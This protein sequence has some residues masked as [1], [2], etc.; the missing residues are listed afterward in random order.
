MRYEDFL[1]D[2]GGVIA[3]LA[4]AFGVE[5]DR[6]VAELTAQ[7]TWQPPAGGQASDEFFAEDVARKIL[8]ETEALA[9]ALGY[10]LSFARGEVGGVAKPFACA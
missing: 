2:P 7:R 6:D 5:F 4:G 3:S 10:D 9:A 1:A 8:D